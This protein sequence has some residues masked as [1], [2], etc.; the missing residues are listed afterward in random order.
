[1]KSKKKRRQHGAVTVFL[2]LILLPCMI[3]TCAFGDV[4]RVA[5][6]KSQATA[7]A[8]LSLYSLMGNYDEELKEWYGLV[9]S[10]QDV[11]SFYK[12]SADYFKGMMDANG[13]D[14]VASDTFLSYLSA[15]Q[16]G[17]FSNFLQVEGL[18]TIEVS[19]A[20]NGCL[21]T[22]PALIEDGIVEFMK[23]RGPVVIAT[24]IYDRFRQLDFSGLMD[25]DE[26]EP[27]VE[28]KQ[29]YAEAE[30]GLMEDVLH[31]YMAIVQYQDKR[32]SS[33]VP[34]LLKY[35]NEYPE[36]LLQIN[37]DLKEMTR[38][39][40]K[41]YAAT[42]GIEDIS[43]KSGHDGFPVY[44]LPDTN[45]LNNEA[46]AV[47]YVDNMVRYT[48]E[49]IG[50]QQNSEGD[51]ELSDSAVDELLRTKDEHI[52]NVEEAAQRIVNSCS[53]IQAPTADNGVNEAIYCM[54]MQKA[55]SLTDL[56]IIH[57]DGKALMQLYAK[58]LLTAHCDCSIASV[59][60]IN[61]AMTEIEHIH[62]DYLSYNTGVPSDGF[63]SI[64]A[65]YAQKAPSIVANVKERRYEFNSKF[66][67]GASVTVGEFL[68]RVGEYLGP[69]D[70]NLTE[71]IS[72]I[73][74]IIN[75]GKLE[76]PAGSNKVYTVISLDALKAKI[77][78]VKGKRDKWG[79]KAN[80]SST[81][82]AKDEQKEYKDGSGEGDA[83]A[84]HLRT[85]GGESAD[86]L[87]RRLNNIKS[88]MT[89]LKDTLES[90]SYGE[91]KLITFKDGGYTYLTREPAIKA[92]RT[93]APTDPQQ[94]SL[95]LK[96]NESAADGYHAQLVNGGSYT[97]PTKN[98]AK[99]GNDPDLDQNSPALY[100]LMN[101]SIGRDKL[102]DA[103]DKTEEQKEENK[104]N[105]EKADKE[106]EKSKGADPNSGWLDGLGE[107]PGVGSGGMTPNALSD[108][109]GLVSVVEK[110][111]SGNFDEFRDQI[112][113]SAYIME[114]FSYSTYNN[115]GKYRLSDEPLPYSKA[116]E[117]YNREETKKAWEEPDPTKFVKNKSLT[118]KMINKDNNKSNL[119]EVEYILYGKPTNKENLEAAYGRIFTIRELLNLISGFANF[120]N[121][122]IVIGI[123]ATVA[124]TTMGIIPPPVT[125]VVIIGLMATLE[126][127]HDLNRL[128]A[129]TPVVIYK[130]ETDW[131]F[132]LS[133]KDIASLFDSADGDNAGKV[134]TNGIYYSDYL[135][136]FVLMGSNSPEVY[137]GMLL[138]T[139]D[140]I[141][142]NMGL[143]STKEDYSL[144]KA[145]CYFTLTGELRVKPL[146]MT[147]PLVSSYTGADG[148]KVLKA[149]DWCTYSLNVTRGYS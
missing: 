66:C 119:A 127:A 141:G 2:T 74:L 33:G 73:D 124:S 131:V 115:E 80:N 126:S 143:H 40:T 46:D 137:R 8:D 16:N 58:L 147:I 30:G 108:L 136:F 91:N 21:G 31:T 95:N 4:S 84:K 43:A 52:G 54:R 107:D 122:P 128:K 25:A 9:A 51:Y 75:G 121:D 145:Q 102:K 57:N 68:K 10:C 23:Y 79:E 64:L 78:S 27:I 110:L 113:V 70:Q 72:N 93:V 49:D 83:F 149:T 60:R 132:A 87:K 34:D 26:N 125:K 71:Q 82:Y 3:F 103:T 22:N 1:M 116:K 146:L 134:D 65:Q 24:N 13:I 144:K 67:D 130:K 111:L 99:A 123:A 81:G 38:V 100:Q 94:I 148:S 50:A 48:M 90:W 76:F 14:G 96:E 89:T 104:K 85:L 140:L 41:Y 63:E 53:G 133:G 56:H 114:M 98:A 135:L 44:T 92:V 138:R 129:G 77:D 45:H 29:E 55:V 12:V 5:L 139:G 18:D 59:S 42:D 11:D 120:Y 69:L 109:T 62:G 118:N 19:A 35:Q 15:M 142:N 28:A 37:D 6:S 36:K 32:D 97:P 7:A 17:D 101:D 112:Y 39:I 88:D 20:E 47:Y 61:T 117:F 86:E 105:Q 106:A